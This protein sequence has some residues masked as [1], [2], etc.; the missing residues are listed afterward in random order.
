M[1]GKHRYLKG[2][3]RA[4]NPHLLPALGAVGIG[5]AVTATTIVA[6][7]G[8]H[9]DPGSGWDQIAACESSGNWAIHTGSFEG[10]LQFSPSTWIANGGGQ[11][12]AHAYQATREQ[13][14]AVARR[15]LATQGIGAWPVCGKRASTGSLAGPTAVAASSK[16][17]VAAVPATPRHAAPEPT[18]PQPKTNPLPA[19]PAYTGP[20]TSYTVAVDDT[21]TQIAEAHQIAD[22]QQIVAANLGALTD[23]DQIQVGQQLKLPVPAESAVVPLGQ[24]QPVKLAVPPVELKAFAAPVV[25]AT[26]KTAPT[27]KVEGTSGGIAAR[28]VAA[29]LGKQGLMYEALDCSALIQTAYRAAGITLPRVAAAQASAGRAV[30]VKDLRPGDLLFFYSPISHVAMYIGNGKIVQSSESGKPIAVRAMY[31]NGLAGARRIVG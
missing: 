5:A 26:A 20:T 25:A 9:A 30:S 13:Q 4:Y 19:L 1:S 12:A 24:P 17:A 14:I 21:L 27:V 23:P 11:F 18:Q 28:A 22:W 31:L 3:H 7:T 15:V 16:P 6:A 29:A 10:G 8:A 2:K